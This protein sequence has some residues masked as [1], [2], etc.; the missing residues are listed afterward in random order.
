M[1]LFSFSDNWMELSMRYPIEFI[2]E[3]ERRYALD[4]DW[5]V[6]IRIT[7]EGHRADKSFERK[8][9]TIKP[10]EWIVR[11]YSRYRIELILKA[12][13]KGGLVERGD[14]TNGR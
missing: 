8:G 3:V 2:E 13:K 12:I 11:P 9:S 6:F 7:K 14:F 1:S 4:H 5:K 10:G